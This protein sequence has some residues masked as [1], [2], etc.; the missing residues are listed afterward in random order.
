MSEELAKCP[1]CGD[2]CFTPDRS[3]WFK[4]GVVQCTNVDP[5]CEYSIEADTFDQAI[6]LHNRLAGRCRWRLCDRDD[7]EWRGDCGE[8]MGI[9]HGKTFSDVEFSFCPRCGKQIE[10][11]KE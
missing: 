11:V 5:G 10:E 2:R 4:G 7:N 9:E 8:S 1:D 6:A 3:N